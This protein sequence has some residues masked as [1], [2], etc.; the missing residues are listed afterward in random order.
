MRNKAFALLIP[1]AVLLSACTTV[2][3][4]IKDNGPRTAS[5]AEG[6]P[7][8]V[9]QQFYDLRVA[10]PTQGL[11]DS[12]TLA[13]YRPY[14]SDHLY[15]TLLAANDNTKNG[16]WRNGDLFSSLAQGPTVAS[17]ADASTIPNSDA[18]NIPLR[19]DLSRDGKQWQDEVLMIREGTCWV[20]DDIRYAANWSHPGSG[21]LGQ[22]LEH[23]KK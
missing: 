16:A 21:T 14:L 11:P 7:D 2:E 5:C 9:A 8:S 12:S 18:H 1:A 13:K 22:T 20:V 10:Q 4:V 23:E 6:G 3:P 19:V 15:Q 17:V